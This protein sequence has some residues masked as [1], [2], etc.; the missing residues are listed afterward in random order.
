MVKSLLKHPAYAGANPNRVRALIG[1]FAMGSPDH[2][3]AHDGRG[4]AF[5]A[6]NILQIDKRNPQ[7]A[8]RLL[9]IFGTANMLDGHRQDLIRAQLE[10]ILA[11]NISANVTEIATKS[12]AK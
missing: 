4:Y 7:V 11:Q 1:G 9:G 12:L 8:A 3:H 10:R 6:D 5:L 2:Y